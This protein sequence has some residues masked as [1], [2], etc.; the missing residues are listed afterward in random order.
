MIREPAPSRFEAQVWAG[1]SWIDRVALVSRD[2]RRVVRQVRSLTYSQRKAGFHGVTERG[3]MYQIGVSFALTGESVYSEPLP[4]IEGNRLYQV[5]MALAQYQATPLVMGWA[6]DWYLP[7]GWVFI[8]NLGT[9]T[10]DEFVSNPTVVTRV[11]RSPVNPAPAGFRIIVA[12][13]YS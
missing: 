8:D 13:K 3:D 11:V 2:T 4:S 5:R 6:L 12:Q 7:T 9:R 10:Y 1:G